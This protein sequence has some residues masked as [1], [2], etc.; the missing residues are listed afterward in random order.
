MTL[1]QLRVFVAVAER[2]HVTQAAATLNMT[3]S[4]AS[5]AI[6]A[7]EGSLGLRLFDRVGRGIALT[8]AGRLL[9]PEA[10]AVL[11]RLGQAVQALD[12]LQGL[13]RGHLALHASQTIAGYWLP[14]LMHHFQQ[15][16]PQVTLSLGIGNTAQ[17]A[18]AVLDGE[19]DLGFVEGD[20]DDPLLVRIP[21]ASDRLVLVVGARHPWAGR[22]HL[23]PADLTG[24]RWVL[25]ER[26]SGTRQVFEDALERQGVPAAQLDVA[27]E[28]PSNEAVRAAV[29]AGA[30]ATVISRLVAAA[31]LATGALVELPFACPE[32]RFMLLRHGDRHRSRAEAALLELI[33]ATG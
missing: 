29:E 26:G 3:Q 23:A 24:T 25:R 11:T 28:L 30:G 9:L 33:R 22:T 31:R 27:M 14:P 7:L 12:E 32:R 20:V 21:V 18:R 17:V 6:A 8:E 13:R 16:W 15:T 19:A 10:K 4:A 5:A 1:D 2:L